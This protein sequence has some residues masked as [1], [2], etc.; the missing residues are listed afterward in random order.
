MLVGGSALT[1]DRII[2]N[3]NEVIYRRRNSNLLRVDE[4]SIP[5]GRIASVEID[6]KLINADIIIHSTG[7]MKIEARHF[8]LGD[9][10]EIK[11]I[12]NSRIRH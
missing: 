1:P 12:I 11:R 8:K 9:A 5:F 10:R 4:V 7:N 6:R 2:I 3:E